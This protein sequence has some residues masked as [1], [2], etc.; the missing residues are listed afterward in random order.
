MC[1]KIRCDRESEKFCKIFWELNKARSSKPSASNGASSLVS[2]DNPNITVSIKFRISTAS[3]L[4]ASTLDDWNSRPRRP[5]LPP[6]SAEAES[7][8]DTRLPFNRQWLIVRHRPLDHWTGTEQARS[9]VPPVSGG[10]VRQ[11]EPVTSHQ[12]TSLVSRRPRVP[13]DRIFLGTAPRG[14]GGQFIWLGKAHAPS[15]ARSHA[16]VGSGRVG[17]KCIHC[18]YTSSSWRISGSCLVLNFFGK[19]IL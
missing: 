19:I 4:V 7:R 3:V 13:F 12:V 14:T 9:A 8:F 10:L 15:E 5:C 6:L 17:C 2:S 11:R 18:A 16:R 1:L